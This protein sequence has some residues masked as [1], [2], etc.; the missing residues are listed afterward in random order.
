MPKPEK[1]S[2]YICLHRSIR[3]HWIYEDATKLKWWLD[4]LMEC[5]HSD[6]KVS[7]GFELIE[8]RRGQSLN[9]LLTWSQMWRVDK[10]TVRRFLKLLEADGM[11][12]SENVKKT[13]RLTVCNYDDYNSKR[14]ATQLTDNSDATQTQLRDNP[15]NNANNYNNDN[16]DKESMDGAYGSSERDEF[17]KFEKWLKE[18][19]FRVTQMKS[20]FT[21]QQYFE[22]KQKDYPRDIILNVL[23]AMHNRKDLLSKNI[24]AYLTLLNWIKRE[25]NGSHKQPSGAIIKKLGTSEAR[26]EAARNF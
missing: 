1:N 16:N 24:S 20:P 26:I 17:V 12:K 19:A 15:N 10:S 3:E 23:Q 2:G 21:I 11:V 8:C 9:S 22:L 25:L 14:N 5:N 4:I 13:T 6:R 7:I 18:K